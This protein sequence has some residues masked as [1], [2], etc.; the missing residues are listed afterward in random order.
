[1][2]G[3]CDMGEGVYATPAV[4]N[5]RLIVRTQKHLVCIGKK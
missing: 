3:E 4:S 5:G 1:V 2:L